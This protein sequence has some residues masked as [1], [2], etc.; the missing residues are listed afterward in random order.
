MKQHTY[1]FVCFHAEEINMNS[2]LHA[3]WAHRPYFM[4]NERHSQ[5]CGG[6]TCLEW[7]AERLKCMLESFNLNRW[8]IWNSKCTHFPKQFRVSQIQKMWWNQLYKLMF[9]LPESKTGPVSYIFQVMHVSA[10]CLIK[11]LRSLWLTSHKTYYTQSAA[12]K[13]SWFRKRGE[14][15]RQFSNI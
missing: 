15:M 4:L 13:S 12:N 9:V 6:G 10:T 2:F 8:E 14:E 3:L 11:T 5:L 7:A 1:L